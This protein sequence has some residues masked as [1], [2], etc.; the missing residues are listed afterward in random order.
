MPEPDDLQTF[1]TRHATSYDPAS[2]TY[3]RPPFAAPVKAGK[4]TPIYN[5]HSYH[6]KVPP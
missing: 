1:L 3:R 4:N 6:T 5:A 2:D